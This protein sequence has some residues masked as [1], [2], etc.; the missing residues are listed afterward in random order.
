MEVVTVD[1][2][3]KIMYTPYIYSKITPI[4]IGYIIKDPKGYKTVYNKNNYEK[5]GDVLVR[6]PNRIEP[7]MTEIGNLWRENCPD[8]RFGQLIENVFG[9]MGYNWWMLEEPR[10][11]E[12]FNKYFNK[13][14]RGKQTR[15]PGRRKR[16]G[17]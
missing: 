14:K 15:K 2:E 1:N 11:L 12:E 4:S 8:W 5:D 6:D 13:G 10:M 3:L 7:F 16:N 17:K 9:E